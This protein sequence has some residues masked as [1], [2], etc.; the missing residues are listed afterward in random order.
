MDKKNEKERS[1]TSKVIFGTLLTNGIVL[2]VSGFII[3]LMGLNMRN[4]IGRM[5]YT[6]SGG[7]DYTTLITIGGIIILFAGIT[8]ICVHLSKKKNN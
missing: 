3:F 7:R 8:C 6:F 2:A 1:T 5:F 4:S